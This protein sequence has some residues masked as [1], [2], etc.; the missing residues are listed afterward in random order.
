MNKESFSLSEKI[1]SRAY[2]DQA[3]QSRRQREKLIK[4][5][6]SN[7]RIPK[8]GW[9]SVSI[10]LFLSE[11]ASMD[12][13]NFMDN[14]GVGEREARIFSSLVSERNY[15]L[16]HGIGR[17]G[18][19]SAVQPKAAGSS[20][21]NKLT[22]FMALSVLK[23][24][25]PETKDCL[26][27]PV[28]TGMALLLTLIAL[29]S[30][31]KSDDRKYVIWPRIDQKTCL[32]S[33]VSAGLELIIVENLLEGDELRTD[34]K[35]IESK[36]TQLGAS[37]V[38]AVVTTSSCFAP[39][40]PDN[41]IEVARICK[42][43]NVG[44]VIN[45]A[46]GLQS[47]QTTKMLST[48]H[49]V[50]RVDAFVQSTDKNFMVPVGG[51]IVGSSDRKFIET[52]SKTYPGRASSSP[53]IDLFITFLS[54]GENKYVQLIKERS[55][56][57]I[58]LKSRLSS[59]AQSHNER[60]LETPNNPISCGI[61]LDTFSREGLKRDCS[62]LGSML[63]KRCCSGMRT[64]PQHIK[65]E[66]C[67]FKFTGY[68]AHHDNYPHP[69]M[70]CAAAIGVTKVEIDSFILRLDKTMIKFHLQQNPKKSLTVELGDEFKQ[71]S[72]EKL[73]DVAPIRT[74][75]ALSKSGDK[76]EYRKSIENKKRQRFLEQKGPLA[77]LQQS[78]SFYVDRRRTILNFVVAFAMGTLFGFII[79]SKSRQERP[80]KSS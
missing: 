71:Q 67:G 8:D 78:N 34:L 68:G 57:L 36:I 70:V 80:R 60:L 32:K 39:R 10:E 9:D 38:L 45:N 13:N 24:G 4:A 43:H 6:I 14:V 18:D 79:V 17:S 19:I 63:F 20:L 44:H 23:I 72:T 11:I 30:Y 48:A 50:G 31:L 51:S 76:S 65:K 40:A 75:Q 77:S 33:I 61:T 59:L 73:V 64:V 52:T 21:L 56:L 46:Y 41:V 15:R 69:Y 7:R 26:V 27:L 22:N 16:G 29:K 2:A 1:I 74:R 5:L 55:E 58:Y 28:A 54:M 66:I 37:N 42:K 35:A 53:L 47:E 12:S 62:Y 3:S 49:K 25:I